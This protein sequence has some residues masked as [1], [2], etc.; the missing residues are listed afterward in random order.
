MKKVGKLVL[1]SVIAAVLLNLIL[2]IFF[3][4]ITKDKK[5]IST[6]LYCSMATLGFFDQLKNMFVHHSE[7]PLT[8]SII[9]AFIVSISVLV[10]SRL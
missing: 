9:V 8:S 7:V 6:T 3:K 10:A 1:I 5:Q 2:P 4:S